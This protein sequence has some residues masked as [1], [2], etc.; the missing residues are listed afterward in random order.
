VR[1][2]G[3][4]LT[5]SQNASRLQSLAADTGVSHDTIRQKVPQDYAK[6]RLPGCEQAKNE[7]ALLLFHTHLLSEPEYMDQLLE[8]VEKVNGDLA[9]AK[10]HFAG[11]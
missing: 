1:S 4:G 2:A 10:R 7:T 5:S 9:G 3:S 6:L 11:Q 8:A